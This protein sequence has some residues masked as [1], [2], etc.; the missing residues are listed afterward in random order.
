[1]ELEEIIAEFLIGAFLIFCGYQVGWKGNMQLVHRYHY[2]NVD[3]ED[4]KNYSKKLGIGGLIVGIG[5]ALMPILNLITHTEMGYYV[6]FISVIG[7]T[8]YLLI[9]IIK[10]NGKLISFWRK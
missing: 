6:G 2:T 9:I 3:P 1:M 5:I 10:Y 8:I 4:M 7:G